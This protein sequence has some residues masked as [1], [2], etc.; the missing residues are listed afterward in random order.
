MDLLIKGFEHRTANTGEVEIGYSVGPDNGPPLLLLHGV[1]SRRDGFF[2]VVDAL[3]PAWRVITMD[4]RGHGY[5]GHTPGAYA[6]ADY[7]RDVRYMLDAVIGEP[8]VVWGH[9]LG[10]GNATETAAT[11][12]SLIRALV[13]EDP[14]LFGQSRLPIA[15]DSPVRQNFR[16]FLRLVASGCPLEEMTAALLAS[17]PAQGEVMARWKAE[18]LRQMDREMLRNVAEARPLGH[19]DPKDLLS[20][21]ACP[22]LLVQADPT[23]GGVLPD[24]YLAGLL[25]S[26][27]RVKVERLAGCGHNTNRDHPQ[28]L[29]G[30]VLP[31]LQKLA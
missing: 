12:P 27:G 10:G 20:R 3:T 13:L 24:A 4:Q 1:T 11:D 2:R 14:A 17:N 19:S 25:P 31:W 16:L 23:V 21:I 7:A 6:R 5:S 28:E 9:S 18:C 29:L 15:E 26:D 8:T 22:V 30:A